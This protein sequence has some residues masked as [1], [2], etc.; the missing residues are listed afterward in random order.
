MSV[1]EKF[2]DLILRGKDLFTPTANAASEELK[3]LQAESKEASAAFN[4]LQSTQEKLLKA[5]GLELYAKQAETALAA[6]R[7]EVTR[8]AREIDESE[9]PTKEQSEAL[10]LA[11]RSAGQ[12]QTE[13]NKLSSK[14]SM[15]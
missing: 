7:A 8:L 5:Q 11:S 4:Q 14:S 3:K 12:L 6:A 1:K 9:K 2:I 15:T 13:Y 10:K